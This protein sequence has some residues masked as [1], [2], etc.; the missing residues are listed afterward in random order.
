MKRKG[1]CWGWWLLL[2][3]SIATGAPAQDTHVRRSHGGTTTWHLNLPV[4]ETVGVQIARVEQ[5]L[6]QPKSAK[7]G[8]YRHLEFAALD[9]TQFRFGESNGLPRAFSGGGLQHAGGFV[10]NFP[11][12][13]ADLR[14]FTL[15]PNARAPFALDVV[16]SDGHAWFALDRGH[17]QLEDDGEGHAS[18]TFALRYMNLHLSA[19]FAQRLGRAELAGLAVGGADTLSPVDAAD[20]TSIVDSTCSAPWP[21]QAA[22]GADVRMVMSSNDAETGTADTI[23]FQRCGLPD[24]GGGWQIATCTATSTDRAVVFAPDTSL[25]NAGTTTVSWH[26]M[27]SAPAAPYGNDQHPFLIWNLYRIDA[28]GALHQLAASG[29]KHAFNTINTTCNC[30][31]HTNSYPTCEDSYSEYSNDIDATT[32]PNYLGPRSE[33]IPARGVFGRCLSVFDKNCDGVQDAD[34]GAEDAFQYRAVVRESDITASLQPNARFLFEYWYVVRDQ[35]NIY[36]AMGY[37]PLEFGKTPGNGGAYL[38]KAVPVALPDNTTFANGAVI[39]YWVDPAAPPP[40]ALNQELV[41]SEGR[42]RVAMRSTPLGGAWYRYDYAVMNFDFAR[43]VVDSAHAS[44][45]DLHVLSADGFSAFVLPLGAGA[46]VRDA[47]FSDANSDVGDDWT[48]SSDA[49]GV[50]WQ[51]PLGHAL[52]W[53]TLYRFSFSADRAPRAAT[54]QLDVAATGSPP[55]YTVATLAP[56]DDTIFGNGFDG[57]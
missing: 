33:I 32:Q 4:L 30:A 19:Y 31:D 14:A 16:G 20:A 49:N 40:G 17:Y 35:A 41:T 57:S 12:G 13:S 28:D 48:F 47:V 55:S 53:G 15:R 56:L 44:E 3:C 38:W 45:P 26:R 1:A 5:D 11:G 50:R 7:R 25:I 29:A 39:N 43:A 37:R 6:P 2:V 42:V 18:G 46:T 34:A 27:F 21:V 10:L 36:D 52:N 51:A 54:A 24:G 9:A 8:G 23:H 22:V